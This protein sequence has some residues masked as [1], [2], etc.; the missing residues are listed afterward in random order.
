MQ[1]SRFPYTARSSARVIRHAVSIDERRARFRQDLTSEA[2]TSRPHAEHQKG[3]HR[4]KSGEGENWMAN[5][6]QRSQLTADRFRRR[7]QVRS[8]V[9]LNR[10][11]SPRLSAVEEGYLDPRNSSHGR[12]R[13][14]SPTSPRIVASDGGVHEIID[15]TRL[16]SAWTTSRG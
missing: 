10:N 1:R 6:S 8:T 15:F 11:L 4:Q 14:T 2:K 12:P 7:S 5:G 9:D 3:A 13:S 16:R